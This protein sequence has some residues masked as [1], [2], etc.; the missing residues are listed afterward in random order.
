MISDAQRAGLE[1][2]G[3]LVFDTPG[4]GFV[5]TLEDWLEEL[6]DATNQALRTELEAR[7]PTETKRDWVR[8]FGQALA[9]WGAWQPARPEEGGAP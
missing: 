5:A 9:L 2:C 4:G 3:Y 7:Y 8:H 1:S 6:F